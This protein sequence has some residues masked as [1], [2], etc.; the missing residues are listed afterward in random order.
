M[1]LCLCEGIS[2]REIQK[3]IC[4][5]AGS[6]KAIS[7]ICGAGTGCGLCRPYLRAMLKK[8]K[9]SAKLNALDSLE[10]YAIKPANS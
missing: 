3:L 8:H 10:T 4:S 6:V 7:K 9:N 2:D 1:I 5:G